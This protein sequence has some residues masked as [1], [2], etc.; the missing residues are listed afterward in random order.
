MAAKLSVWIDLIG[1]PRGPGCRRMELTLHWVRSRLQII[2]IPRFEWLCRRKHGVCFWG[3]LDWNKLMG[4]WV[5]VEILHFSELPRSLKCLF[6]FS[7]LFLEQLD[8]L[9]AWV[10]KKKTDPR[11]IDRLSGYTAPCFTNMFSTQN[12]G[13][14]LCKQYVRPM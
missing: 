4:S 8:I 3:A 12:E 9:I 6:G 10:T 13:T 7:N 11:L 14:H 1:R 2:R 5:L